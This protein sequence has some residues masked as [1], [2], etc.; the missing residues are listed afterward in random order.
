MSEETYM[1]NMTETE[2]TNLMSE[3]DDMQQRYTLLRE[4][5]Q[6]DRDWLERIVKVYDRTDITVPTE[7]DSKIEELRLYLE[8]KR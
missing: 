8:Q 7:F 1:A 6:L 5:L 3:I 2:L 4:D